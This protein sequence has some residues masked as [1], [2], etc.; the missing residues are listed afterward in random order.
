[1]KQVDKNSQD[2]NNSG[3]DFKQKVATAAA[4]VVNLYNSKDFIDF[5]INNLPFSEAEGKMIT[6]FIMHQKLS[7]LIFTIENA[8]K[9][10]SSDI[11]HL[12]NNMGFREYTE[13][14]LLKDG[15]LS[16][17]DLE[18]EVSL[19]AISNYLENGNNYKIYHSVNDY[20]ISP[21]Q[22]KILKEYSKDKL[23]LV[24]NGAHL[25]F[26]YRKEFIDDLKNT[27]SLHP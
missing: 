14:Y 19:N 20:L 18:F 24:D 6:G 27:I 16:F 7:D 3:D 5:E 10:K 4:K 21:N 12:V 11:Y 15:E 22:L 23:V 9:N 2:W 8:P 1:M 26:M 25:G 17:E 13:K